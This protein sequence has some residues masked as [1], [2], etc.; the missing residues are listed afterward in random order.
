MSNLES[1][2]GPV[3]RGNFSLPEVAETWTIAQNIPLGK[4]V[5]FN[6]GGRDEDIFFSFDPE[7]S[8]DEIE[9][10]NYIERDATLVSPPVKLK[11]GTKYQLSYE[12]RLFGTKFPAETRL[13][14]WK[15]NGNSTIT[16]EN[17]AKTLEHCIWPL[18]NFQW[19]VSSVKFSVKQTAAYHFALRI[20][21][22]VPMQFHWLSIFEDNQ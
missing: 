4:W 10:N 14:M 20:C 18:D 15:S 19:P 1:E 3:Y 8:S 12:I 17:K 16:S 11:A 7:I 6:H 13:M 21:N 9:S 2:E 22:A 5:Y